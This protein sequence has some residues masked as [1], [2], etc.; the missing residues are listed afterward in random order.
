MDWKPLQT[1][2]LQMALVPIMRVGDCTP[3]FM[4]GLKSV[5]LVRLAEHV[6]GVLAAADA[7]LDA[8]IEPVVLPFRLVEGLLVLPRRGLPAATD[9]SEAVAKR[10]LQV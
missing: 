7:G 6:G 1:I 10:L 9:E 2:V 8:P 5:A 4:A 3:I